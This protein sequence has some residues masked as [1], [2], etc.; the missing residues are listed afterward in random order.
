[1]FGVSAMSSSSTTNTSS[2]VISTNSSTSKI[3]TSDTSREELRSKTATPKSEIDDYQ[4]PAANVPLQEPDVIASTKLAHSKTTDNILANKPVPPPRLKRKPTKDSMKHTSTL[5]KTTSSSTEN[6]S[7]TD[8][9]AQLQRSDSASQLKLVTT[10]SSSNGLAA[11]AVAAPS[12]LPPTPASTPVAGPVP[13]PKTLESITRELESSIAQATTA[14]TPTVETDKKTVT[15]SMSR[16]SYSLGNSSS[17]IIVRPSPSNSA[18][19][20]S[21]PARVSA[22]DPSEGLDI[23]KATYGKYVVKPQDGEYNKAEGPTEVEK[24]Q[25]RADL[26]DTN[27]ISRMQFTSSGSN[28]LGNGPR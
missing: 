16:I 17:S 22:I 3:D 24:D 14:P 15:G 28:S 10:P 21:A 2:S 23:F 12:N 8:K 18:K 1:M 19:S 20:N 6:I 11:A 4:A 5:T 25:I 7:Q 9:V 27:P 26:Y 13:S